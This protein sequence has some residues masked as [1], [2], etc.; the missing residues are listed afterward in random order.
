MYKHDIHHTRLTTTIMKNIEKILLTYNFKMG[1]HQ[2]IR[3]NIS[4]H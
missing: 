1:L 3:V 2:I 4:L